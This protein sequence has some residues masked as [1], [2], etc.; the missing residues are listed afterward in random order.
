M[1]IPSSVTPIFRR[2]EGK[3]AVVTGGASG[4]GEA[5]TRLFTKHGAKVV[6]ADVRNDLGQALCKELGSNDT[7]SF[8]HCDVTNENDMEKAIDRAVSRLMLKLHFPFQA[9]K[10]QKNLILVGL[11]FMPKMY[12]PLGVRQFKVL[13]CSDASR[14]T[15]P[16]LNVLVM[17]ERYALHQGSIQH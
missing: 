3:V 14:L 17:V 8:T 16:W 6:V 4:I 15:I 11:I 10:M 9:W 13:M 5:A 12:V 1:G 2:L 7:I